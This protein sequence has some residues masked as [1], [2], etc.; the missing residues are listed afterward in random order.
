M[1][2]CRPGHA[3]HPRYEV[4]EANKN[5][6]DGRASEPADGHRRPRPARDD[7]H[8]Y[9]GKVDGFFVREFPFAVNAADMQRGQERYTAYCTPCHGQTGDGRHGGAA[10]SA[11]GGHL[12][13][14][15]AA[16]RRPATS[17]M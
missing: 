10:R 14:G 15:P 13:P 5:Y 16:S 7:D 12:P 8:F 9:T 17:T 3:R 1:A 2:G 6:P 4:F 11:S